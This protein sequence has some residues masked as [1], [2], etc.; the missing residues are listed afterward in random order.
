VGGAT[1]KLAVA[2]RSYLP[3]SAATAPS[4]NRTHKSPAS[5]PTTSTPPPIPMEEHR[6]PR[7][8]PSSV[9][10]QYLKLLSI[11]PPIHPEEPDSILIEPFGYL[12]PR[13]NGTTA[14]G[15]RRDDKLIQVTFWAASL[16]TEDDL[17]LLRVP[18]CSPPDG[19]LYVFNNE[20]ENEP[21]ARVASA[22]V[23]EAPGFGSWVRS[24]LSPGAVP[25]TKFFPSLPGGLCVQIV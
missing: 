23:L 10:D 4:S 13:T 16:F 3:A 14:E 6:L 5:P 19:D 20:S 25:L 8:D 17:V 15:S 2:C 1:S 18:I 21:P 24:L 22:C 9:A 7:G 11:P 12:S